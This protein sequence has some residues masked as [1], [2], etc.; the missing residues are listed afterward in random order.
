MKSIN[1]SKGSLI[2][3][4]AIVIYFVSW[5]FIYKFSNPF[6]WDTFGYYLY[7]PL[8]FI[9]Q[10]L[11][12]SD[13]TIIENVQNKQFISDTLYQIYETETGNM[14]IRYPLGLSVLLSP[15]YLIGHFIAGVSNYSQDGFSLPYQLAIISGCLFYISASILLLRKILL[16][17]FN[18]NI[19][20]INLLLICIGTN[21]MNQATVSSSMPHTLIFFIYT[22]IILFTIKWHQEKKV[23]Y[24]GLIGGVIGLAIICRPTE[25]IAIL[26]PLLWEVKNIRDLKN[27]IKTIWEHHKKSLIIALICGFFFVFLQML[28]WKIYAG[29]FIFNSYNNPGEGLD[30]LAPHIIAV[31]FSFI[32]N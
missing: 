19:V 25:I 23:V 30:L 4:I 10:D 1:N 22:L 14:L 17:W 3:A 24:A 27:K 9:Y 12:I 15:F 26:I 32:L 16:T 11:G 28:Y 2:V 13:F 31:L 8:T 20:A 5:P 21:D 7:L 18:D 29:S 6:T